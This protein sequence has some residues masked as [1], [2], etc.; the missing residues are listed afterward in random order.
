MKVYLDMDGVLTNF[1]DAVG[2]LHG[3]TELTTNWN[4]V[5][6]KRDLPPHQWNL[7][8]ML[9]L[10]KEEMWRRVHLF[11]SRFWRYVPTYRWA[12]EL[13]ATIAKLTEQEP[14]I[15]SSPSQNPDC[16][17][18]KLQWIQDQRWIGDKKNYIFTPAVNKALLAKPG[19]VL[20][21][22]SDVNYKA[23]IEEGGRAILFPQ[24]WNESRSEIDNRV[25]HTTTILRRI[26]DGQGRSKV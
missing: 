23:F 15:V 10:P 5:R 12:E 11:G 25:E 22:D 17:K 19:T 20:I 7:G 13:Y 4:E 24:P 18:G 3:K 8:P 14:T 16:V 1:V 6:E 9:G 21:D 26:Q 2:I